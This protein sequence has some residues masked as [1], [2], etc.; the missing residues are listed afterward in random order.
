M[1]VAE[2]KTRRFAPPRE[3]EQRFWRRRPTLR[4]TRKK[5]ESETFRE[6]RTLAEM[7]PMQKSRCE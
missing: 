6:R 3:E 1:R 5:K 4:D 2:N 7:S